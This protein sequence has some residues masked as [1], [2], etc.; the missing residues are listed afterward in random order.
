MNEETQGLN[1]REVLQVAAGA[2][3]LLLLPAAVSH[4]KEAEKPVPVNDTAVWTAIG[5]AEE[6]PLNTPTR[7]A[8]GD[9]A[10][11]VTRTDDKTITALSLRCTHKGCEVSWEATKSDYA[12]PCH[13]ALFAADGKCLAGTRRSPSELMEPLAA[14]PARKKG[15]QIELDLSGL[16]AGAPPPR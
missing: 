8:V 4:A 3:A 13:G 11:S 15:N 14:V 5:K 12:C 6:F 1:R 7:V 9:R 16:P 2:G 10:L